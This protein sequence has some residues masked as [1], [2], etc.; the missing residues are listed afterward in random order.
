[1]WNDFVECFAE[2]TQMTVGVHI[3]HR[4]EL[5]FDPSDALN[6]SLYLCAPVGAIDIA[7]NA[8]IDKLRSAGLWSAQP[9][10]QVADAQRSAY[11]EQMTFI[12]CVQLRTDEG[13]LLLARYTHPKF[14]SDDGRW[15]KWVACLSAMDS[16]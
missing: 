13:E 7:A 2:A 11:A 6:A 15:Q 8:A 5:Y 3:V 1:L 9:A 16:A 12:A 10:K 4:Y 14:A